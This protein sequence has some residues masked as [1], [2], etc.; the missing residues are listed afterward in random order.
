MREDWGG[1]ER[2]YLQTLGLGP[3]ST[4]RKIGK[5]TKKNYFLRFGNFLIIQNLET[6][7]LIVFD[8]QGL[9]FWG[10]WVGLGWGEGC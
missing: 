1:G 3:K 5:I 4:I 9:F 10:G 7:L 2:S 8:F 6:I